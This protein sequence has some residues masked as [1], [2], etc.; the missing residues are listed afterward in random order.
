VSWLCAFWDPQ[1]SGRDPCE[2]SLQFN[3]FWAMSHCGTLG[4]ASWNCGFLGGFSLSH[5]RGWWLHVVI[6]PFL[7]TGA[8]PTLPRAYQVPSPVSLNP[9]RPC[10]HSP[11][12]HSRPPTTHCPRLQSRCPLP[13]CPLPLPTHSQRKTHTWYIHPFLTYLPSQSPPQTQPGATG[14]TCLRRRLPGHPSVHS[15]VCNHFQLLALCSRPNHS[16]SS[17]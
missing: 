11:Q 9:P 8:M 10:P 5:L 6:V 1:C 12:S 2:F 4:R 3:I 13:A 17:Q 16:V 14:A 7:V 15:T